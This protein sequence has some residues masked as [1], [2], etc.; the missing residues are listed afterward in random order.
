MQS[1]SDR[2][3]QG[4]TFEFI[5]GNDEGNAIEGMELM[6][7]AQNAIIANSTFSWWAAYLIPR[8]EK[9][10]I[11]P[12]RIFYDPNDLRVEMKNLIP[13]NQNGIWICADHIWK[14]AKA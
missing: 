2:A 3:R 6:K 11:T 5:E 9:I 13:T 8:R 12:K 4:V 14:S 1:L 7:S 10:I